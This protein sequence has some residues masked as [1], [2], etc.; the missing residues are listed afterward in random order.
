[1]QWAIELGEERVIFETDCQQV[2][3]AIQAHGVDL[4]EFGSTIA[5]CKSILVNHSHFVVEFVRKQ[6]NM[7]AHTLGRPYLILAPGF[8]IIVLITLLLCF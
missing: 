2:V 7:N 1:M 5:T 6:M 3:H 8:F 4:S